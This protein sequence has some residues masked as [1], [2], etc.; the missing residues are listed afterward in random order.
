VQNRRRVVY[1]TI[2][3][4]LILGELL[5]EINYIIIIFLEYDNQD[6]CVLDHPWVPA[7]VLISSGN[8]TYVPTIPLTY[9]YYSSSVQEIPQ[10]L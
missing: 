8:L 2:L 5:G 1:Y 3:L 7:Y 10:K 6:I 9:A 4:L